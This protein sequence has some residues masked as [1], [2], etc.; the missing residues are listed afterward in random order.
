MSRFPDRGIPGRDAG[1]GGRLRRWMAARTP[2][3]PGPWTLARGRIYILPTRAGYAYAVLVVVLL[4]GATNYSNSLVFLLAFLLAALGLVAMHQTDGNLVHLQVAL[5]AIEPVFAGQNALVGIRL[6]NPGRQP[7]QALELRWRDAPHPTT[8]CAADG[9]ESNGALLLRCPQRG[10]QPLPVLEISTRFPLGLFRAWTYIRPQTEVLVYPAPAG[11][12]SP[13]P[14]RA[15]DNGRRQPLRPGD[16]DFIGLRDYRPGDALTAVHWK[17]LSRL[18]T[19][20]VKQFAGSASHQRWIDWHQ[21]GGHPPEVRLAQMT[22][23][24]LDCDAAGESFG[25]RLP[26]VVLAPA[27]GLRQR[28]A[29]LR[30]LALHGVERAERG[31]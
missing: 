25:L 17:S 14:A 5:R 7:R 20:Q 21:L 4:L 9:A 12:G 19:P 18:P 3:G 30:A 15:P 31:P 26:G 1:L 29:G 27:G 22:R 28:Q 13:P 2:G 8:V 10:L 16:D 23:W 24:L 6:R 11:R